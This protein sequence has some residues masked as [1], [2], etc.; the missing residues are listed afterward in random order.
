MMLS[1]LDF[2]RFLIN[3]PL[4]ILLVALFFSMVLPILIIIVTITLPIAIL[5][6][7]LYII[8]KIFKCK[9]LFDK[10]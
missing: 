6:V 7:F 2:F 1:F 9:S 3:I 8:C 10:E 5:Y 4:F